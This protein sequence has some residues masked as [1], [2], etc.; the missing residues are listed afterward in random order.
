MKPGLCNVVQ[1]HAKQYKKWGIK[2]KPGVQTGVQL[3]IFTLFLHHLHWGNG[4]D[5]ESLP[6]NLA[7]FLGITSLLI[8]QHHCVGAE[9][10]YCHKIA[11]LSFQVGFRKFVF[12][13]GQVGNVRSV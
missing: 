1:S 3:L 5:L 7:G 12:L 13:A 9:L 4:F 2:G 11:G 10:R 8:L 6:R